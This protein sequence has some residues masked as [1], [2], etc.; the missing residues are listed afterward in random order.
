M[1]GQARHRQADGK[2]D[3][4]QGLPILAGLGYADLVRLASLAELI[5]VPAGTRL[6]REGE[7][8]REAFL[9]VRGHLRVERTGQVVGRLGPGDLA[10]DVAMIER[11]PRATGVVA[12]TSS[13]VAVV[14]RAALQQL[15][16]SSP[17][18]TDHLLS[19]LARRVRSGQPT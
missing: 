19:Q 5:D 3:A 2:I 14:T 8:A 16:G 9:V 17:W 10:G 6:T 18:F 11:R 13:R 7:P 4:L 12:E 15:V 1:F